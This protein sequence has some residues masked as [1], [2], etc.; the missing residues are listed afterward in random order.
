MANQN[1][2]TSQRSPVLHSSC[3]ITHKS[4][5]SFITQRPKG[6]LCA[7][8]LMSAQRDEFLQQR[9]HFSL[10]LQTLTP[11]S[12]AEKRCILMFPSELVHPSGKND[13]NLM[14]SPETRCVF[15]PI[16]NMKHTEEQEV[17]LSR[18]KIQHSLIISERA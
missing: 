9:R 17:L 15:T 3:P 1:S 8:I 11:S 7:N 14:I 4:V 2:Q 5:G 13:P 12:C 16:F 18:D 10:Q 6:F